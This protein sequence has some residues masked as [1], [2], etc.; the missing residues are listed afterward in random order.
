MKSGRLHSFLI[1][2]YNAFSRL[3]GYFHGTVF[4]IVPDWQ[5][6]SYPKDVG[7]AYDRQR[8]EKAQPL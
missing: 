6:I 3:P 8:I 7:A 2:E 4:L 5:F 1:L